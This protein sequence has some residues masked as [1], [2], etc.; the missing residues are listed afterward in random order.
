VKIQ[1][2]E[3]G[4]WL[5]VKINV[6][7]MQVIHSVHTYEISNS[8]RSWTGFISIIILIDEAFKYGDVKKYCAYD[9][10]N[11]KL[12]CVEF[13]HFMQCHIL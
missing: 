13:F 12:L 7:F 10:I 11:T 8:K 1:K 2:H 6:S 4:V 3:L 9:G 5:N